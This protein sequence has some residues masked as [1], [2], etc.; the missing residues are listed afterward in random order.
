MGSTQILMESILTTQLKRRYSDFK[1]NATY[2]RI[3]RDLE[4]DSRFAN[5]RV[6]DPGNPKS[7]KKMFFSPNI[8]S[9]FDKHYARS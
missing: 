8:I 1:A 2:H 5:E 9:E 6:L 7:A 3:R 4:T